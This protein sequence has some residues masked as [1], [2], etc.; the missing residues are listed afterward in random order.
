MNK[1]K[2]SKRKDRVSADTLFAQLSPAARR[3]FFE[4]QLANDFSAFVMKVFETARA[5]MSFSRIGISMR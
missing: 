1:S 4:L 5:A 3:R 2:R